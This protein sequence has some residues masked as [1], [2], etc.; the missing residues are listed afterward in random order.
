MLV[1]S[2]WSEL[3]QADCL[4]PSPTR[5]LFHTHNIT[6]EMENQ[7]SSNVTSRATKANAFF[8]KQSH[9]MCWYDLEENI[10]PVYSI[11]INQWWVHFSDCSQCIELCGHW[12]PFVKNSWLHFETLDAH[13]NVKYCAASWVL[14]PQS[15]IYKTMF[16]HILRLK[17]N[18]EVFSRKGWMLCVVNAKS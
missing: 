3:K 12:P 5:K 15:N 8:H 16:N 18:H 11:L 9:E 1:M 4:S 13:P 7:A 14:K 17:L 6:L 2:G 10:R